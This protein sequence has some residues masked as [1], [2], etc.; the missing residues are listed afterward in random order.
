MYTHTHTHTGCARCSDK[1]VVEDSCYAGTT[2]TLIWNPPQSCSN[3]NSYE[4]L[5]A[6]AMCSTS[7]A[8]VETV[9][10]TNETTVFMTSSSDVYC[11]RVRAVINENCYSGYS[12]CAQVASLEQGTKCMQMLLCFFNESDLDGLT[13]VN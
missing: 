3:V 7:G 9:S 5:Y 13:Q 1:P 2:G 6:K 8:N 10:L 12:T 4:V 11:I